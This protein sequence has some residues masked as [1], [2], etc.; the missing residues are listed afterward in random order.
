M[1]HWSGTRLG[2]GDLAIG[3]EQRASAATDNAWNY[4][5]GPV[6]YNCTTAG[7]KCMN[8]FGLIVLGGDFEVTDPGAGTSYGVWITGSVPTAGPTYYASQSIKLVGTFFDGINHP[9]A[10][11]EVGVFIDRGHEC[12]FLGCKFE[13]IDVGIEVT[14]L[15]IG[16]SGVGAENTIQNCTFVAGGSDIGIQVDANASDTFIFNPSMSSVGTGIVNNGLRTRVIGGR[17]DVVTPL[18]GSNRPEMVA[19]GM[20]DGGGGRFSRTAIGNGSAVDVFGM[21]GVTPVVKRS[22]WTAATGTP[23]RTTFVTSTVTTA[24]LAEHVKALIDDLLA[25]GVITA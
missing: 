19:V 1:N 24:Q 5:I 25:L 7:L 3:L 16:D 21:N 10:G 22:G 9:S 20:P 13:Q 17:L 15:D 4:L 14:N 8:A 12:L 18:S 6:F 23:T 11:R 2:F